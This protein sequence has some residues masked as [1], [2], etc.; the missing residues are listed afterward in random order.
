[1]KKLLDWK[2]KKKATRLI[3]TALT[4]F[5][6]G[7]AGPDRLMYLMIEVYRTFTGEL[8]QIP[9]LERYYHQD[10]MPALE[11]SSPA[12]SDPN[13]IQ[14]VHPAENLGD[15]DILIKGD[16]NASSEEEST[17]QNPRRITGRRLI[18]DKRGKGLEPK[19]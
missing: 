13:D 4:E 6:M 10:E 9:G 5:G 19:K 16:Q 2:R 8:P 3:L 18:E 14:L 11:F 1:M 12:M 17:N 7:I 15:P